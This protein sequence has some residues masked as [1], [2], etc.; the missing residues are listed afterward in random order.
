M[1]LQKEILK[2]IGD[3]NEIAEEFLGV[4]EEFNKLLEE[5]EEDQ[6]SEDV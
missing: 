6:G 5:L 1:K 4:Q 2:H 3:N